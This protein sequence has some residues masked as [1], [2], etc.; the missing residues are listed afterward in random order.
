MKQGMLSAAARGS[1]ERP[2]I[3]ARL[4][5]MLTG[6]SPVSSMS[7]DPAYQPYRQ[8]ARQVLADLPCAEGG[9][10]L[11]VAGVNALPTDTLLTMAYFMCDELGSRLLIVDAADQEG[12]VGPRLG[13]SGLPGLNDL[14]RDSTRRLSE[15]AQPTARPGIAALGPG[16]RAADGV[17]TLPS[18]A[19]ERV[20]DEARN[21]YDYTLV[22]LP[23]VLDYPAFLRFAGYADTFMLIVREGRTDFAELT[24]SRAILEGIGVLNV[25]VVLCGD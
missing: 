8:L 16:R 5:A 18:A 6:R 12:A 25:R 10:T 2:G 7:D 3:L 15:L 23:A 20:L 19:V 22:Q 9:R 14:F 17:A 4:R 11:F 1:F 13:L 24:R 21:T